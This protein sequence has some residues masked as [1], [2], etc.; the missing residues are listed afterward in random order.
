ML[1]GVI[2]ILIEHASD[3]TLNG[4]GTIGI[5]IHEQLNKIG[6]EGRVEIYIT[7]ASGG[8]LGI[9]YALS[10][11]RETDI[12]LCQPNGQDALVRSIINNKIEINEPTKENKTVIRRLCVDKPEEN[13]VYRAKQYISKA[14][15]IPIHENTS[16]M[17]DSCNVSYETYKLYNNGLPAKIINYENKL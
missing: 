4:F 11:L 10:C 14:V 9:G 6:I 16:L 5:D 1:V 3:T 7:S 8:S 17:C 15:S 13:A 12:I 2:Y